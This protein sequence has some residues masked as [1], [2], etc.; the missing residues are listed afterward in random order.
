MSQGGGVFLLLDHTEGEVE[1]HCK[2]G[3]LWVQQTLGTG[4]L[5]YY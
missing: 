1:I 4:K 5:V 3:M 2:I